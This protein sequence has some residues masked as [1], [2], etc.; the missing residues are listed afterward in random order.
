MG[1]APPQDRPVI[2]GAGLAGLLTAVHLAP[3][4]CVVLTTGRLAEHTSTDLA[5]GGIAAALH[6]G[7][8]PLL[9]ALDTLHAGAGLSDPGTAERITAAAP[10]AVEHLAALGAR[11]DRTPDG[12]FTL[13]LEAA[14][15][16]HRVA[17]AGGD[18][19][20]HEVLR[21]AIAAVRATPSITVLQHARAVRV[22]TGD[23]GRVAGVVVAAGGAP[24]LIR[25][26]RVVLATGG[27][28]GLF[29]HTTNPTGSRGQGL[30]LAARAGAELRDL[31]MVQFH[32]TALDV[33]LDPMPLVTEA[34]RGAGARL[35]DAAG[36]RL[37]EDD[38]APRDVVARAVF[39]ELERGGRV[40]LDAREALGAAARFPT[41]A[42]ACRAAG[43]DPR[44]APMPVRPA[45]HY[46]MG[47]VS[48]DGRGRTTVAGLWAVGEVASTGLHGANRLASNSLLEAA[49]CARWVAQDV[50]GQEGRRGPRLGSPAP[51][52]G[53]A[54]EPAG[55]A[56]ELRTLMSECVGVLRDGA[57]L[58]HAVDRLGA[59][60]DRAG[61]DAT[62]DAT[63]AA[64]LLA[65]SALRRE[66]SRG[67][68]TRTDFPGAAEPRHLTLTLEDGL[69]GLLTPAH[70]RSAT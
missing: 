66:E 6:P 37:L 48:V 42:A 65:T 25:T 38:L 59:T 34:L 60:V 32:P 20:G 5:Q 4:P 53:P 30:A 27:A 18:A 58:T 23:D 52:P 35:V 45:A 50:A 47:G 39:A 62:D 63:L 64:L 49:V 12:A 21:A 43:I 36:D 26:D 40:F 57:T 51:Q 68:H 55:G 33:G 22:V 46:L 2:V 10:A 24:E 70:R 17:H 16:R 54:A 3:L 67:A 8:S 15:S 31:E 56:A 61:L 44:R 1:A 14:H 7:D 9:H 11:F 29:R 19:T 69:G 13:G 41:V 28:G